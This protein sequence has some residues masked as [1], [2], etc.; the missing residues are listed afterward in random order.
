MF[1]Y[2]WSVFL[3]YDRPIDE[4]RSFKLSSDLSTCCYGFLEIGVCFPF[5]FFLGIWMRGLYSW[6]R[7]L[8]PLFRFWFLRDCLSFSSP[9]R[10]LESKRGFLDLILSYSFCS[11]LETLEELGGKSGISTFANLEEPGSGW[12]LLMAEAWR[13]ETALALLLGLLGLL[14]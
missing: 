7:L 2:F 14:C 3:S 1:S 9:S 12:F 8:S 11:C 13:L 4:S 10:A 6:L 5:A